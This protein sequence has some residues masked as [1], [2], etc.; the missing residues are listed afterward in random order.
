MNRRVFVSLLGSAAAGSA[1]PL[2]GFSRTGIRRLEGYRQTMKLVPGAMLSTSDIR[3]RLQGVAETFD[4]APSTPKDPYL[5]KGLEGIFAGRDTSYN[6]AVVEIS[7][8]ATPL[9]AAVRPDEKRIPGSVGKILIA[10]GIFGG[11][12]RAYPN[13]VAAR[14]RILKETVI[15]AD[16]FVHTDSKTVPYWDVG[17][18]AVANR[19]INI[20]DKFSLWEW[21]DHMLSQSSNA[22]ASEVWKHCML[23]FQFGNRYP[24]PQMEADAFF[25]ETSKKQLSELALEC[26]E[27]AL[28]ES[29]LDITKLRIGSFFTNNAS[30]VVP[31]TGSYA[32]PNELIRWLVKMEQGK[33]VDAWSSL[34]LK[35]LLYFGRPRYRYSSSPALDKAA[36]YF[37]SGSLF[38]CA[39]EPGFRCEQY[40]GNK[41]NLMHSVAVVESGSKAYLVALMSNVLRLNSAIEHQTI[42]TLIERLIQARP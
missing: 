1:Y 41:L 30:S 19:R 33:L 20:G 26:N 25:K 3:L 42:A 32:T 10:T 22:A 6:I 13:D 12:K 2:D 16:S 21:L 14:E 11:L 40:K 34:E 28:R 15:T 36:V 17:R 23:L 37:K 31:G 38:E 8:P 29:G 5:Q 7:N 27:S 4:V 35:R 39:P 18:K 9:Y 24:V